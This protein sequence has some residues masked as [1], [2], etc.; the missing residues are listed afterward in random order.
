MNIIRKILGLVKQQLFV[1]PAEKDVLIIG[2]RDTLRSSKGPIYNAGA[3]TYK[4]LKAD[5]GGKE[6]FYV[7]TLLNE[8]DASGQRNFQGQPAALG[9]G[10]YSETCIPFSFKQ[11]VLLKKVHV[12]ILAGLPFQGNKGEPEIVPG[13]L[14]LYKFDST[15]FDVDYNDTLFNFTKVYQDPNF[16]NLV[17]VLNETTQEIT[18]ETPQIMKAGEVYVIVVVHESPF[19]GQFYAPDIIETSQML[20]LMANVPGQ[21]AQNEF[22]YDYTQ[23]EAQPPDPNAKGIGAIP[24]VSGQ[25]PNGISF[26]REG[27]QI[28][29]G[30]Q[31]RMGGWKWMTVENA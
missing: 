2:K 8:V 16:Y 6:H 29:M 21:T 18:L 25:L 28:G 19:V 9:I 22:T 15:R 23:L 17:N 3:V 14:G 5:V 31:R 13:Y 30:G 24:I 20:G 27:T 1:K 7:D 11:D 26:L 4:D 12:A 10:G